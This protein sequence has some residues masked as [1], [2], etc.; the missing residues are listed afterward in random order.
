MSLHS[1]LG[2]LV[3]K[4][5]V[6]TT[7]NITEQIAATFH[8]NGT[9]IWLVAHEYGTNN[10][11]AYLVTSA[12]ITLTPVVS[13]VGPAHIPC[14]SNINARGEIKFSPDGSKVAF[15]A[16]G[17][18]GND[19][20]N[21]L[22]LFDFDN[23]TGIVSNP[24]NLP[25][26]RGDFGLS[27]SSDNS[28]LYGTTWK[29]LNFMTGDY[30]YLYQFDLSSGV[31]S[32]IINSKQIIDSVQIPISYG[33][34]KLA[35]DGKI[36]VARNN[37]GYLGVIDYPN[38]AGSACNYT[39]NGFYLDGK[40]CQFGLNNYIEYENYCVVTDVPAISP[41]RDILHIFP[42]PSPG[43]FTIAFSGSVNKGTIEIDNLLGE[44]VFN[45]AADFRL[46]EEIQPGNISPGIYF[47][48]EFDGEKQYCRKLVIEKN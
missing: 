25:F 29:A 18:G 46:K 32:T 2:D 30:N 17:V 27:F 43:N 12:G 35:P 14:N 16:N 10:F 1:G 41:S 45:G 33:D 8:N 3:S 44:K 36:Y 13:G 20:A 24:L 40:T 9:D 15:N 19:S 34:I 42:N 5:N 7:S 22:A 11:L 6:L 23:S 26:S 31:P 28:K 39:Y 4:N 48:R 47:V 37:S 21:I 38:L